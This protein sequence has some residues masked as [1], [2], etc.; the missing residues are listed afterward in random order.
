MKTTSSLVRM[1]LGLLSML[2]MLGSLAPAYAHAASTSK[3]PAAK[4]VSK[5]K[6]VRKKAAVPASSAWSGSFVSDLGSGASG[7]EVLKLQRLLAAQGYLTATPNGNFGPATKAAVT[8]FQASQGL[9]KLGSVGPAT[10]AALNGILLA[11]GA[12]AASSA[13]ATAANPVIAPLPPVSAASSTLPYAG[14][15][16]SGWIPY[17]R[18]ATGTADVQ[19]H[20]S[21]LTEVN[22]FGYT[23][24][25]NGTLYDALGVNTAPW[26][27]FFQAARAQHVRV[28]PTV[29][30]SDT[31]SIHAVLSDPQLRA[32]HIASIVSAVTQN[33]FDGIDIDYEGKKAADKDN[34]SAFLIQLNAALKAAK[35]TA[36]L[37]CTVEARTPAD[38]LN[39]AHPEDIQYAN[40]YAVL[41]QVCDRVRLMTYDQQMVDKQLNAQHQ[42]DLYAPIADP[43]WIKKVIALTAQSIDKSKL[44]LGIATYGYDYQVIPNSDH[45]G[46]SYNL[47]EAFNPKYGLDTASQLNI[48]PTRN[49]AGELSFSYVPSDTPSALPSNSTLSAMAPYGTASSDLAAAGALAFLSSQGRQ[50]PFHLLWWSDAQAI[51]DRIALAR[52]LGLAGVAIFKFDGGEDPRMWSLLTK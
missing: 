12:S 28:V 40:D 44:E 48:T 22:P 43:A 49:A 10:R 11:A 21:Q 1:S 3:A 29:M 46:Y 20:L 39:T 38:S 13:A 16:I 42:N 14:F 36:V 41:N 4:A 45:S 51:Q 17:W 33:N 50:A 30:W 19:P 8:A 15:E 37:D 26:T 5:A 24:K 23:V 7:T 35:P 2:F 6:T 18:T 47:I 32:Q 34:F 31:D 25:T 27:T 9:P 52:Q